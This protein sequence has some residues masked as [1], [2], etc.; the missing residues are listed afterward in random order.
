MS[1]RERKQEKEDEKKS[2]TN[3][4]LRKMIINHYT[5][6]ILTGEKLY[7]LLFAAAK[8][9]APESDKPISCCLWTV[10]TSV[11][12]DPVH[13]NVIGFKH[14]HRMQNNQLPQLKA[15][16]IAVTVTKESLS[17]ISCTHLPHICDP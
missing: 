15:E 5:R 4:T 9:K 7:Y 1:T 6:T 10:W 14:Y 11:L 13:F 2:F 3:I 16:K 17:V 12:H 8:G